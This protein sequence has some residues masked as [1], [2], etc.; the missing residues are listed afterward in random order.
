MMEGQAGRRIHSILLIV[1]TQL[2]FSQWLRQNR[3]QLLLFCKTTR[4]EPKGTNGREGVSW[5]LFST[6][7]IIV[8][9]GAV[10]AP[11]HDKDVNN[12]QALAAFSLCGKLAGNR[13]SECG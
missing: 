10:M 9:C 6:Y 7:T 2:R 3:R 11:G 12:G 8:V 1:H 5:A 13:R 4:F